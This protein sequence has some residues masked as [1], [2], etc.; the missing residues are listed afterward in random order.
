MYLTHCVSAPACLLRYTNTEYRILSLS[1]DVTVTFPTLVTL[2][3]TRPCPSPPADYC[4]AAIK[5]PANP[6]GTIDPKDNGMHVQQP[7]LRP[8]PLHSRPSHLLLSVCGW[9]F[10][11][12]YAR[13]DWPIIICDVIRE[14]R[15]E[16][17]VY[18]PLIT[19]KLFSVWLK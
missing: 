6:H 18:H 1:H 7:I 19:Y 2:S 10:S 4:T 17:T 16:S 13:V 3:K 5:D 12:W 15:Y 9:E 14:Q 8:W 11:W